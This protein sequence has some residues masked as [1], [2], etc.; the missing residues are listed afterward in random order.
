M[1]TFSLAIPSLPAS[2]GIFEASVIYALTLLGIDNNNVEFSIFLHSVTFFP[3]T[4]IGGYFFFKF[5]FNENKK[6]KNK[7]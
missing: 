7:I 3:Y 1:S 6:I 5:Y 2:I 4:F